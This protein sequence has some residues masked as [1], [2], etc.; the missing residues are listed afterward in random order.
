MGRC[1]AYTLVMSL[2]DVRAILKRIEEHLAT[3]VDAS[4]PLIKHIGGAGLRQVT[5][6]NGRRAGPLTDGR[7]R[8]Q[9]AVNRPII[10]HTTVQKWRQLI[11][12]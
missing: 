12:A 10:L 9:R 2:S 4:R 5:Y 11:V 6:Q 1:Y 7:Q 3:V 8:P